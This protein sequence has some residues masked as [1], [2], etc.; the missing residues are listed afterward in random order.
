M[1]NIFSLCPVRLQLEE[2]KS[3]KNSQ[4]AKKKSLAATDASHATGN[5]P[6]QRF[7]KPYHLTAQVL[8]FIHP[9]WYE[10]LVC[11]E[12]HAIQVQVQVVPVPCLY[13]AP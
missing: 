3:K 5:M 6:V 4:A 9:A 10:N 1:L 12:R 7:E 11:T 2:F 8:A 13:Q